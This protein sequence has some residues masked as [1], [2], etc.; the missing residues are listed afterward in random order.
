M[1]QTIQR[2][3]TGA[4]LL[5]PAGVLIGVGF[6]FLYDHIPAY[7]LIGLGIG[8]LLFAVIEIIMRNR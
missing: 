1:A 8:F 4:A 6:G 5:I 2:R 3:R 7:T